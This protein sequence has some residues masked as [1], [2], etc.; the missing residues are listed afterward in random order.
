MAGTPLEALG[1]LAE[2]LGAEASE[3]SEAQLERALP[4]VTRILKY[5]LGNDTLPDL[6][7]TEPALGLRYDVGELRNDVGRPAPG[8]RGS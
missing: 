4:T 3:A 2:S 7:E 1:A 5:V 6:G 8:K